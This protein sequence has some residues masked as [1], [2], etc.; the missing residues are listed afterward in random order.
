MVSYL[1]QVRGKIREEGDTRIHLS[2]SNLEKSIFGE[3]DVLPY[4][5]Q[6]QKTYLGVRKD[7]ALSLCM[8][9]TYE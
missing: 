9:K 5:S 2:L 1:Y 6:R 7:N 8:V 3:F 4:I